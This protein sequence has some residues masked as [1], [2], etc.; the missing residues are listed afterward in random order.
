MAPYEISDRDR[1]T[2][3]SRSTSNN[4]ASVTRDKLSDV[5]STLNKPETR[6]GIKD[7][8]DTL[9]KVM[10]APCAGQMG[11]EV[12]GIPR[13]EVYGMDGTNS[14]KTPP[15][16]RGF[17]TSQAVTPP[18]PAWGASVPFEVSGS[19][20]GASLISGVLPPQTTTQTQGD[21]N[22]SGISNSPTRNSNTPRA[23]REAKSRQKLR[24]LGAQHQLRAGFPGE[25]LADT[26]RP[27]SPNEQTAA[28]ALN[29]SLESSAASGTA[30]ATPLIDFDDGISA[31]SS[32]TLEEMERRRQVKDK[33]HIVRLN[34]QDFSQIV[35]ASDEIKYTPHD[36]S[37][38]LN[39]NH[40]T[41]MAVKEVDEKD[42]EVV[43]GEPFYQATPEDVNNKL[44][45]IEP[46]PKL[47]RVTSTRTNQTNN[48]EDSFEEYKR[49]EAMYWVD[50]DQVA[51]TEGRQRQ[52]RPSQ[53]MGIEE[54]ARRLRELSRSRSRSDGTGSVSMG[55]S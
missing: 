41:L 23:Q 11:G 21:L 35:S 50:Q 55:I 24:Q 40:T 3:S 8:W 52:T 2:S 51:D 54:R 30:E 18:P 10:F 46:A 1:S 32:H 33:K 17:G 7:G 12:G 44:N 26:A 42:T 14:N 36:N 45:T 31:I 16:S 29:T 4:L 47:N 19:Q 20:V 48:T 27:I 37:S 49:H 13:E 22:V 34:P 15:R 39:N 28:A 53:R 5:M 38:A 25:S 9:V 43:F 6:S